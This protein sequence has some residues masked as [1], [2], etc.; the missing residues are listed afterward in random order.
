MQE[1]NESDI[2]KIVDI[3]LE[4]DDNP[5]SICTVCGA[6]LPN[7]DFIKRVREI[8]KKHV[9]TESHKNGDL[10]TSCMEDYLQHKKEEISNQ[11]LSMLSDIQAGLTQSPNPIPK[12]GCLATSALPN[13]KIRIRL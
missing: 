5:L 6:M 3:K 4:K 1:I 10:C 7:E 12:M 9:S 13:S 2:P 11:K 8:T